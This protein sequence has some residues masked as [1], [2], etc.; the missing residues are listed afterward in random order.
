M[1][2]RKT[3]LRSARQVELLLARSRK[4][5][6]SRV[7]INSDGELVQQES[8]SGFYAWIVAF[9]AWFSLDAAL[10]FPQA[11]VI[12]PVGLLLAALALTGLWD[13]QKEFRKHKHYRG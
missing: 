1:D 13:K 4:R 5:K 12:L 6:L 10:G 2:Y 3:T 7:C 9:I 11:G 8:N